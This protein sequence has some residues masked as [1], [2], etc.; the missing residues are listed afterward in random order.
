MIQ[1]GNG[2]DLGLAADGAGVGLLA[3][4]VH[5]GFLGDLALVPL[6]AGG[7]GHLVH[8]GLR[9][10]LGILEQQAAG[11][12]LVILL[13][14]AGGA[15]G[16]LGIDLCQGVLVTW[17]DLA[18]Y[19]VI[20]LGGVG[21]GTG[22]VV[23]GF[24]DLAVQG[25]RVRGVAVPLGALELCRAGAVI[26]RPLDVHECGSLALGVAVV[27]LGC[28]LGKRHEI[29]IT[30]GKLMIGAAAVDADVGFFV[31]AVVF[32][33]DVVVVQRRV[34]FI[35]DLSGAVAQTVLRGAL[36]GVASLTAP[37][38]NGDRN[39]FGILGVLCQHAGHGHGVHHVGAPL[40]LAVVVDSVIVPIIG[41]PAVIG[42]VV[43]GLDRIL[44]GAVRLVG[45]GEVGADADGQGGNGV[46]GTNL[47]LTH[48]VAVFVGNNLILIRH[49]VLD[50]DGGDGTVEYVEGVVGIFCVVFLFR[51]RV[52]GHAGEVAAVGLSI[53]VVVLLELGDRDAL[54]RDSISGR[55]GHGVDL[56][57]QV[58]VDHAV[59]H[60]HGMSQ[61]G[62]H[63]V[64][65]LVNDDLIVILALLC[66][67]VLTIQH[68]HGGNHRAVAEV[69]QNLIVGIVI[70]LHA[71]HAAAAGRGS[72]LHRLI[73]GSTG[74]ANQTV[75][76]RSFVTV[77]QLAHLAGVAGI[78]HLIFHLIHHFHHGSV[79]EAGAGDVVPVVIVVGDFAHSAGE[80]GGLI[81]V[82]FALLLL[83]R[84]VLLPLEMLA[85]AL[86][87]FHG[88]A[89]L[90]PGSFEDHTVVQAVDVIHGVLKHAQH[91]GGGDHEVLVGNIAVGLHAALV[92]DLGANVVIRGVNAV[93]FVADLGRV[94]VVDGA[95]PVVAFRRGYAGL[96]KVRPEPD[97]DQIHDVVIADLFPGLPG[98]PVIFLIDLGERVL[99][100]QGKGG[101]VAQAD[102]AVKVHCVIQQ[103]AES[104][105][106]GGFGLGIFISG[107]HFSHDAHVKLDVVGDPVVDHQ[108]LL[109]NGHAVVQLGHAVRDL[110]IQQAAVAHL[111]RHIGQRQV[112]HVVVHGGVGHVV[113]RIGVQLG[114]E[115]AVG[116]L[117]RVLGGPEVA[118]GAEV[119]GKVSGKGQ[120]L[121]PVNLLG[122]GGH[123]QA[124][125]KGT[126]VA[127]VGAV[128]DG[129]SIAG[130]VA[131]NG[132]VRYLV[133]LEGVHR[134]VRYLVIRHINDDPRTAVSIL[135]G[136]GDR[137]QLEVDGGLGA[138]SD[139]FLLRVVNQGQRHIDAVDIHAGALGD[140]VLRG[141]NILVVRRP[142]ELDI[143]LF[144]VI[145]VRGVD[146]GIS[147]PIRLVCD[148]IGGAIL[149]VQRVAG[150]QVFLNQGI[151]NLV[152]LAVLDGDI[153]G[154]FAVCNG[155]KGIIK[156][157]LAAS[158]VVQTHDHAIGT[159]G[160]LV[161]VLPLHLKGDFFFIEIGFGSAFGPGSAFGSG[162]A[163]ILG[164]RRGVV[165]HPG[166][167]HGGSGQGS[168]VHAPQIGHRE[169]SAV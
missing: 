103:G 159:V 63:I 134:S 32:I 162:L 153:H 132:R 169:H 144:T 110:L 163:V 23:F 42:V 85:A 67:F 18:H 116:R 164:Q 168:A 41:V 92:H 54:R 150:F 70:G 98:F 95:E 7:D 58:E 28:T 84:V 77:E 2:L 130:V 91:V 46:A 131:Q 102:A 83:R 43:H 38:V 152:A 76:I 4:R 69:E 145:A 55:A 36:L 146:R 35:D 61:I 105:H 133:A 136:Q 138:V 148:G 15:G 96:S 106:L 34:L 123:V 8:V 80:P 10:A 117:L 126:V 104:R 57:A 158:T 19:D 48:R 121:V 81:L 94:V 6:V 111:I 21:D 149:A 22:A 165:L 79:G 129:G 127:V 44:F 68:G 78:S 89:I 108:I 139:F 59:I 125:L 113:I 86:G 100:Q 30:L 50:G 65:G 115:G 5:G 118:G 20:I 88:R 31:V 72:I 53:H 13:V 166:G 135:G 107:H 51:H 82:V 142:V 25:F 124:V 101:G 9:L 151:L 140:L 90:I 66:L 122:A 29:L 49:L 141:R 112:L 137:L 16:G 120:H 87:L 128:F 114:F 74:T 1:S 60:A 156:F 161:V 47:D 11:V 119:F 167:A 143:I 27:G 17:G 45:L 99:D 14:A 64:V 155:V 37:G 71:P 160:L 73:P 40:E 154:D 97:L 3:L 75:L 24:A 147:I 39:L 12:A 52:E 26:L 93:P 62:V 33:I 56:V 109:D 157:V